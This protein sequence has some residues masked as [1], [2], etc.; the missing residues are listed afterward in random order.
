MCF[1]SVIGW[2]CSIFSSRCH[3]YFIMAFQ[4]MKQQQFFIECPKNRNMMR[5]DFFLCCIA[6]VYNEGK[7]PFPLKYISANVVFLNLMKTAF[8]SLFFSTDRTFFFNTSDIFGVSILELYQSLFYRMLASTSLSSTILLEFFAEVCFSFAVNDY[9]DIESHIYDRAKWEHL[10]YD[11]NNGLMVSQ[12]V[13]SLESSFPWRCRDHSIVRHFS[14][15]RAYK[16][17]VDQCPIY[18]RELQSMECSCKA[19]YWRKCSCR[20]LSVVDVKFLSYNCW[21]RSQ[22]KQCTVASDQWKG[23]IPFLILL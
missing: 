10:H 6:S 18:K 20:P 19:H 4:Q 11:R 15:P 1:S 8:H 21:I 23:E 17:L 14:A 12:S 22:K 13:L 3:F 9:C 7:P 5:I 16:C 2:E